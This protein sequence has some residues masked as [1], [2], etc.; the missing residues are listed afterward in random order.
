[1]IDGESQK[2]SWFG[3][4]EYFNKFRIVEFYSIRAF[5][6]W[7]IMFLLFLNQANFLAKLSKNISSWSLLSKIDFDSNSKDI[8]N[9]EK[10]IGKK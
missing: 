5:I 8:M 7:K 3:N 10:K 1:M 2:F 9:K 6:F 4:G